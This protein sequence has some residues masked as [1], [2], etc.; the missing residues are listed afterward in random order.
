MGLMQSVAD[1]IDQYGGPAEL[2]RE[3]G[4]RHASTVSEWKRRSAIPSEYW[5]ELVDLADKRGL[6]GVSFETL[7][8]LH[9]RRPS[10]SEASA[11]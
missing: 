5:R 2:T 7:A 8:D 10:D 9:A 3:L 11:A 6:T 1:I 4:F